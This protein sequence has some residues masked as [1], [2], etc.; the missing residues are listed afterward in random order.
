MFKFFSSQTTCC[1][2]SITQLLSPCGGFLAEKR[3]VSCLSNRILC[4]R[5]HQERFLHMSNLNIQTNVSSK[6]PALNTP[7]MS[8]SILF[9][10]CNAT[11]LFSFVFGSWKQKTDTG[12]CKY[13]HF[14]YNQLHKQFRFVSFNI[15]G[16]LSWSQ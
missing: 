1:F 12:K 5:N 10:L 7:S 15:L 13:L 6:L 2:L 3:F 11:R 4:D 16:F 14:C 8:Q 9:Y